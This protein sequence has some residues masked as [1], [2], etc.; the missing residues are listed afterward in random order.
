MTLKYYVKLLV[1]IA[2]NSDSV[3]LEMECVYCNFVSG[4]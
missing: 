1:V 3:R 4:Y 2:I